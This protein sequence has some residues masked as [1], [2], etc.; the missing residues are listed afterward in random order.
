MNQ[1]QI[2]TET[3]KQ[4]KKKYD[5]M[6]Q[7]IR[8]ALAATSSTPLQ[9]LQHSHSAPPNGQKA[10]P[11][12]RQDDGAGDSINNE[13]VDP[14]ADILPPLADGTVSLR[15]RRNMST[16]NLKRDTSKSDTKVT[17]WLLKRR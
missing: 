13:Q 6:A 8:D 10:T 9:P 15:H 2:R 12:Q 3:V 7:C 17:G 14:P 5:V 4:T 1:K 11:L 16:T